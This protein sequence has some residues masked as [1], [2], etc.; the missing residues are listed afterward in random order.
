MRLLI[1]GIQLHGTA[2]EDFC[3]GDLSG[4]QEAPT[5]IAVC[6]RV[7]RLQSDRLSQDRN[8]FLIPILAGQ[9]QAQGDSCVDVAGINFHG[10]AKI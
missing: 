5:Q 1:A 3:F 8:G 6:P 2:K 4:H 9:G 7:I 10:M